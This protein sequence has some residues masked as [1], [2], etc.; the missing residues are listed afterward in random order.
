MH[1]IEEGLTY[2]NDHWEAKYPWIRDPKELPNNRMAAFRML[3][4]NEKR[5][6]RNTK[7]AE[8]YS[9]HIQDMVER[10]VAR[11]L[12]LELDTYEGPTFYL[13][14]HEVLKPDSESTPCRIVF[15]SSANFKGHVLNDYCPKGLD[16]LNN[17]L[18]ILI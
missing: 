16:I 11:K 4:S 7:H 8:T 9:L 5:L 18:G 2:M 1:Q 3:K 14:H 6:S 17:L 10:G 13:S 12:E 15:S